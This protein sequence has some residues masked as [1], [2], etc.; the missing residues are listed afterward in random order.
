MSQATTE[1]IFYIL[2]GVAGALWMLSLWMSLRIG[3]IRF[4]SW[5]DYEQFHGPSGEVSVKSS[6]DAFLPQL[7]KAL[8]EQAMKANMVK[9]SSYDED[10][11]GVSYKR[12][13]ALM[14]NLP[15]G[16]IFREVRFDY[17]EERGQGKIRYQLNVMPA[18]RV[19]RNV[20]LAICLFVGVPLLILVPALIWYFVVQSQNQYVRYQVF[21][22]LQMGHFLWM[23]FL[24]AMVSRQISRASSFYIENVIEEADELENGSEDKSSTSC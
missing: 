20:S 7:R 12:L 5:Q 11:S 15:N 16:L 13:G 18:I 1:Q 22:M 14:C 8:R 9:F 3:Q 17:V 19:F 4:S 2:F 21:Q 10:E 6:K 24:F 23:P